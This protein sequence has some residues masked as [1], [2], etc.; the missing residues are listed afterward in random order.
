MNKYEIKRL[1][2][3]HYFNGKQLTIEEIR[4]LK[5]SK[6]AK[7]IKE[8]SLFDTVVESTMNPPAPKPVRERMKYGKQIYRNGVDEI[9]LRE[10]VDDIEEIFDLDI[11]NANPRKY[12]EVDVE[13]LKTFI[14]EYADKNIVDD[15]TTYYIEKLLSGENT[16]PSIL[17]SLYHHTY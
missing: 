13:R 16:V 11:S 4:I 7:L 10:M 8:K 2:E 5:A 9:T 12:Q 6:Y 14:R 17:H 1:A 3:Q 15:A